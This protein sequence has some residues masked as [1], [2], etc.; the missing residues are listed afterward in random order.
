MICRQNRPLWTP[1]SATAVVVP[2]A[3]DNRVA[4]DICHGGQVGTRVR[5][6]GEAQCKQRTRL[7]SS[8]VDSR[9]AQSGRC[10]AV[11]TVVSWN[12]KAIPC[13][14]GPYCGFAKRESAARASADWK[15]CGFDR[16]RLQPGRSTKYTVG[17]RCGYTGVTRGGRQWRSRLRRSWPEPQPRRKAILSAAA[18]AAVMVVKEQGSYYL[19]DDGG[20][21]GIRSESRD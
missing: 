9:S 20:S 8:S 15:R 17:G 7:C 14:G 2:D 18:P 5:R 4:E 13:T 6:S 1:V 16:L 10:R 3:G 21:G 12:R 19:E 11:D